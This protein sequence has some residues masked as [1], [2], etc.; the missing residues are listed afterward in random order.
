MIM[1]YKPDKKSEKLKDIWIKLADKM[2]GIV[3][4]SA[5]NCAD[6]QGICEE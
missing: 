4:V 1:Y 3:K 2:N 6:S 5:V